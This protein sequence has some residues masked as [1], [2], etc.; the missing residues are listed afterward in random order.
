MSWTDGDMEGAGSTI[1]ASGATLTVS[2]TN[3]REL[4]T[5][6]LTNQDTIN[7]TG[8]F[9]WQMA[10]GATIDNQ[11]GAVFDI[12]SNVTFQY[13]GGAFPV[14]NSAGTLLQTTGAGTA[15]VP[16]GIN[17]NNTG[18]VDVQTGTL[19]LAGGT[20][21]GS[22][23]VASGATLEFT[24]NTHNLNTGSSVTGAGAFLATGTAIVNIADTFTPASLT[25]SS[26]TAT[27]NVNA[28]STV[29]S[30]TLSNGV[31]SGTGALTA[32]STMN[33]TDGDMEGAGS[34]IIASGAT[35]TVSGT[36]QRKLDTRTLTNQGTIDVTGDLSWQMQD[37][38][39]IDNQ[40]GGVFDIQSDVTFQY[41]GGSG[42]QH[43]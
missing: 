13:S 2:G 10:N 20:S 37:G 40:S 31:L 22:F 38:A 23:A 24:A 28:T 36:N 11:S 34:T 6:T 7:V 21:T 42:K 30:V 8:D 32:S 15:T 29:A 4:D 17:L 19:K 39:T 43:R 18:S 3:Q 5:R 16:N 35:L 27:V 9:S 25:V 26:A 33:W 14:I 41:T 1:I 12:Q